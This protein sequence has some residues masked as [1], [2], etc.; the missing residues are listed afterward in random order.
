MANTQVK[1]VRGEEGD[2]APVKRSRLYT[3]ERVIP[4]DSDGNQ[5]R[6]IHNVLDYEKSDLAEMIAATR[7]QPPVQGVI[8]GKT[9]TMPRSQ[10]FMSDVVS[11]YRF[12]G[13]AL[14]AQPPRFLAKKALQK[15]AEL[16]PGQNWSAVLANYY[17]DG[18]QHISKHSD[19]EPTHAIGAPILTFSF[20]TSRDFIVRPK[21]E[22]GPKTVVHLP[23]NSCC[24]MEGPRFQQLYT[25]EVPKRMKVKTGQLSLTVRQMS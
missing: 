20:G 22:N 2:A 14:S 5:L 10:L 15:A 11:E 9:Y 25:H 16:F 6:L 19:D 12:S 1:R 23:H 4:L 18:T 8:Y 13:Q 21:K 7:A 24:I 17:A 3:Y